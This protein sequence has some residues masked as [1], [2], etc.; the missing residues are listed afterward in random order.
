MPKITLKQEEKLSIKVSH[1]IQQGS[2]R[3]VDLYFSLPV[4]MGIGPRTLSEDSYFH[5][6]I[7]GRRAYYTSG[8]HLPLVQTRFASRMK[9]LPDEYRVY[10][11]LFAYQFVSALDIDIREAMKEK[12]DITFYPALLALGEQ[13][14][15]LLRKFRRNAPSDEKLLPYFANADNYLSWHS[16]Q[17]LLKALSNRPKNSEFNDAVKELLAICREENQHRSDNNYNSKASLSD[18]NRIANKMRL[19]KR[20]I[21][22]GV[23]FREKTKELGKLTKKIVTGVATSLI[24]MIVL[25]LV[26]KAQGAL[27]SITSIMVLVLAG[28]YGLREVFKEDFKN[29]LWRLIRKGK[30]KWSRTILDSSN[31]TPIAKQKIWLDYI[32]RKHLPADV[33]EMLSRRHTQNKQ[34]SELLHYRL[35][36]K[37][38][39]KGFQAGYQAVQESIHFNLR[40]FSRYLEKGTGQVFSE[41]RGRISKEAIERRYQ[42]NIVVGL[43]ENRE[44]TLYTRYKVTLSRSGIVDIEQAK[45]LVSMEKPPR[46]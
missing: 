26:I 43:T 12:E 34:V 44:P 21:E 25:T 40:P 19:L 42:I 39:N 41:E 15:G 37:V 22:H 8:L 2:F 35:E 46:N 32:K 33:A 20:L 23:I 36:T 6:S 24:M 17:S 11:N 9:R 29:A 4:E 28:I 13:T 3:R 10:L 7:K 45:P 18:P 14:K 5:S 30:P 16:E 31:K 1:Q 27:S 38:A